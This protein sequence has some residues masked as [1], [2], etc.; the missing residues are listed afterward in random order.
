MPCRFLVSP[1]AWPR[2]VLAA[3][4]HWAFAVSLL[5]ARA[6]APGKASAADEQ[7]I[8]G[9]SHESVVTMPMVPCGELV[10]CLS[11]LGVLVGLAAL[12]ATLEVILLR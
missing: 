11:L 10:G 12:A 6:S 5:C 4:L 2:V 8:A 7:P 1:R 9:V 3:P